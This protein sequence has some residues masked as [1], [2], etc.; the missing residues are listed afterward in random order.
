MAQTGNDTW[1]PASG[2]GGTDGVKSVTGSP[3]NPS[4]STS[5]STQNCSRDAGGRYT[6]QNIDSLTAHLA[7]HRNEE[8]LRIRVPVTQWFMEPIPSNAFIAIS[9]ASVRPVTPTKSPSRSAS[10][11]ST[12]SV[13]CTTRGTWSTARTPATATSSSRVGTCAAWTTTVLARCRLTEEIRYRRE[14][15]LGD[16]ITVTYQITGYSADGT[17]WRSRA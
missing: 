3:P 9:R 7:P 4:R 17:R 10:T 1:K 14:V 5:P 8:T 15:R 12:S 11:R 6:G 2:V 16:L 13:I